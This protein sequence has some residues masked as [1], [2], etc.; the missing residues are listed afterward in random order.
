[1]MGDREKNIEKESFKKMFN[2]IDFI[3]LFK[4]ISIYIFLNG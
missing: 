3:I 2:F 1:M 4:I